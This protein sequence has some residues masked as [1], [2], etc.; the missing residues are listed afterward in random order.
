MDRPRGGAIA[1][2][3]VSVKM[4]MKVGQAFNNTRTGY[5]YDGCVANHNTAAIY[6][7]SISDETRALAPVAFDRTAPAP[8]SH[9]NRRANSIDGQVDLRKSECIL[10]RIDGVLI[11][12]VRSKKSVQHTRA[13][14][15]TSLRAFNLR[16][17]FN[18]IAHTEHRTDRCS[19]QLPDAAPTVGTQAPRHS[20][21]NL[22]D[23]H[24]VVSCRV[25]VVVVVVVP[26]SVEPI[27]IVML[28][29]DNDVTDNRTPTYERANRD[30]TQ[31]TR[32]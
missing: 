20:V 24:C 12:P 14:S 23:N 3:A 17:H 22:Y 15:Q 11:R 1:E 26:P 19:T 28:V 31:S 21:R 6:R 5:M 9:R 7:V 2:A 32:S 27:R 25:V 30:P 10:H 18:R 29:S 16:V 4:N 13:S 8:T